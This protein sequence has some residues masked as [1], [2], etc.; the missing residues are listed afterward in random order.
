MTDFVTQAHDFARRGWRVIPLHRAV[1]GGGCSCKKGTQC[2]SIGK[3]PIDMAWQKS[4]PMSAADIQATWDVPNPPNLGIAVGNVSG[5]WVLDIDPKNGGM[6][7]MAALVAEHSKLPETF[8][9]QTGSGGFHYFFTLPDFELRNSADRVGKG[10]DTRAVGG[11]VVT[12]PSVTNKGVYTVVKDAP[13][14]EAPA[15]LLELARKAEVDTDEIVTAKD[16]PKP[17]DLTPEQ[18][19]RMTRYAKRAITSELERLDR[20]KTEGWD[21]PP[22]NH[23][24]FEVAC[25]LIEFANS[26][27]NAYS[28]DHARNDLL[29]RAPRDNQGFDTYT[30]MKCWNSAKERIGE[31]ARAMPVDRTSEP[32]PLFGGPDVR[33]PTGGDGTEAA[34]V[35]RR[36]YFGGEKGTTPLY[37]EMAQGVLDSGPVGWGRDNDFWSY[38]D[39]VWAP[40]HYC[41]QHRLVDMLGNAYK[42]TH[43]T[44]TSDVVQRHATFIDGEALEQF[45]NFRNG[46]VDWRTGDVLEHDPSYASTVR[47]GTDWDPE[48]L[49][50][51]FDAW[52]AETLHED[53]VKLAWEMIGY[54]MMSGNPK[55]HAFLLYG[56]G[57]SGKSTLLRVIT[58]LL[59]PENIAA[60]TLD[61][62]STNKFRTASLFGRIANIA[63]DIDASYQENT[64]TFKRITGQD[65]VTA[66]HKNQAPFRFVNWAVPVFSANKIPGSADVTEGYLRRWIILRFT[67]PVPP[68]DR[69]DDFDQQ[70]AEELPGIAHKAV[71][72]LRTMMGRGTDG[73]FEPE[74][75]AIRGQEEFAEAIDQVRQ[76]HA[77]GGPTAGPE[78][79]T[80]LSDLYAAYVGWASRSDRRKVGEQEFSHRLEAIGYPI[81]KVAGIVFHNGISVPKQ[82]EPSPSNF[83]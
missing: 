56:V 24:T 68:D 45:M 48:A 20:L 9:V 39:G 59:G 61:D 22:W 4:E 65:T 53:Y 82:H 79:T 73:H 46:M 27:W 5:F 41:V 2:S 16:L 17:E 43:T 34:P 54:L 42:R 6:E 14:A 76:W 29:E 36:F 63:G 50:P 70:L 52:L 11:Q 12:A 69:V 72:A 47:L 31:K 49:C 13:I 71:I 66:E 21:G 37:D 15:W 10:I 40:D 74:G 83:F 32:D 28:I 18:W 38:S 81:T 44:N 58:R 78:V 67:R 7:T 3:H 62:L 25:S 57:G 19:D 64:A 55:H 75:E 80:A 33:N 23:T 26:P 51:R 8:V 77:S 35:T 60:E 1:I 30:V